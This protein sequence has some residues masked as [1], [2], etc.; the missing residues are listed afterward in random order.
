VVA[1]LGRFWSL[2][3]RGH[4]EIEPLDFVETTTTVAVVVQWRARGPAEIFEGR[5]LA[6]YKVV[7]S[8]ITEAI[9]LPD[10]SFVD[11]AS[12]LRDVF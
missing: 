10:F 8:R 3:G 11:F 2:G 6:V 9:F 5:E 4:I 1:S 12:V 7:R